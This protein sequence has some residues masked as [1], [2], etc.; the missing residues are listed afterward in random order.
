MILRPPRSTRTD[1]LFPYT[2]LF[3]SGLLG[4]DQTEQRTAAI[5][6]HE[7]AEQQARAGLDD[8]EVVAAE[9]LP[10][11]EVDDL[12]AE[13]ARLQLPLKTAVTELHVA[14]PADQ[15]PTALPADL[16]A[17]TATQIGRASG[18]ESVCTSV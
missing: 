11:P 1:T 6:A 9:K 15:R 2:T 18:E 16:G 17:P 12:D 13:L 10:A 5:L 14:R 4:P 7:S 8:P 3:R